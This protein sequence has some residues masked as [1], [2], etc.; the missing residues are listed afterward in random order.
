[1]EELISVPEAMDSA[2]VAS[3]SF[4]NDGQLG[5]MSAIF[6]AEKEIKNSNDDSESILNNFDPLQLTKA[7][8]PQ[9]YYTVVNFEPTTGGVLSWYLSAEELERIRKDAAH[10]D[11]QARILKLIE[12][13]KR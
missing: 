5:L 13:W 9:S 7:G 3:A 8:D 10:P 12:W 6:K 11:T 4:R 1:V 2:R